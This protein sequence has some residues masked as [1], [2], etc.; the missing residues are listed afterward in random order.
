VSTR[1]D[2]INMVRQKHQDIYG[3]LG[4]LEKP[5]VTTASFSTSTGIVSLD[6]ALG[7]RL[8]SGAVEIFGEASSGKT[9]LLFDIIAAAQRSGMLVA[10][11]PSE[12]LD[13]PYMRKFGVDLN[14][15]ILI[16]GNYGEDVLEGALHF[17]HTHRVPTLLALDSA[18]GIRPED[19][20][21]GMWMSMIDHFL[22]SAL[23][24]LPNGSCV[25]MVN[26][27]RMKRSI[28][29]E[30]LRGWGSDLDRK[31]DPGLVQHTP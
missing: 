20:Q 7:G 9:T 2:A 30:V 31:E 28:D 22:S 3:V 26:Q 25:V 14:S 15:L 18:T 13:I 17:L 24:A 4:D 29:P 12:Y 10:L 23:E 6:A 1:N 16:T 8:P 21:P 27:V 19:D 11:C 5:R